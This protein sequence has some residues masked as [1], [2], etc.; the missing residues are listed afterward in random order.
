MLEGEVVVQRNSGDVVFYIT[1][2]WG[3]RVVD[4]GSMKAND[5]YRFRVQ[6]PTSGTTYILYFAG[7][8]NVKKH[9]VLSYNGTT[10]YREFKPVPERPAIAAHLSEIALVRNSSPL[11]PN[12]YYY[13]Y[14]ELTN[15]YISTF[16]EIYFRV[17]ISDAPSDTQLKVSWLF[18]PDSSNNLHSNP[19]YEESV[20]TGGTNTLNFALPQKSSDWLL[21]SYEVKLYLNGEEKAMV[22]FR[23]VAEVKELS[24]RW[25]RGVKDGVIEGSVKNVG[26]VPLD[27]V[28]FESSIYNETDELVR[29]A[30][31]A[32]ELD[33][34]RF[35]DFEGK[36]FPGE[37][38]HC[39]VE[40]KVLGKNPHSYDIR[41][42]LPSGEI[43]P[44]NEWE[45]TSSGLHLLED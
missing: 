5:S 19:I 44:H 18:V 27:N 37:T 34:Q 23:I 38:G 9:A 15:Y 16:G 10:E 36:L 11:L 21:G 31:T 26:N 22:P 33:N 32:V 6:A 29:T 12:Q 2:A 17:K 30:D 25:M 4:K 14:E 35:D 3:N 43:I 28:Q 1:D 24:I 7:E 13:P 41:F 39:R 20:I 42:F 45:L 8:E 40:I